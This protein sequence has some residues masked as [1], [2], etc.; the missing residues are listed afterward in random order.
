MRHSLCESFLSTF[1]TTR[2]IYDWECFAWE[3]ENVGEVGLSRHT[4]LKICHRCTGEFNGQANKSCGYI[5]ILTRTLID[6]LA[7][8][9][10]LCDHHLP[11][12]RGWLCRREQA[13]FPAVLF[14]LHGHSSKTFWG[15]WPWSGVDDFA[16]WL[17]KLTDS[18][19]K[20]FWIS[21]HR[22][23]DRRGRA[24][25]REQMSQTRDIQWDWHVRGCQMDCPHI[26]DELINLYPHT[27]F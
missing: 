27:S 16:R 9:L 19:L 15:V 18:S 25:R 12:Q 17:T 8:I 3:E 11:L 5:P 10:Q 24:R 2:L 23:R 4:W 22:L 20:S 1:P 26:Q 14:E 7:L 6:I 13:V 21:E